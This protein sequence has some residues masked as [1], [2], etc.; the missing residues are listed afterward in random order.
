MERIAEELLKTV[1]LATLKLEPLAQETVAHRPEPDRWTIK[2][3]IGHLIDSATNNHQRFVRAQFAD[4][5]VF[6]KYDQNEWVGSQDYDGCEWKD[7]VQLWSSYNQHIAHVIRNVRPEALSVVCRV[8]DYEPMTLELLI[9]DYVDHL[10][11]H[12]RKIAERVGEQWDFAA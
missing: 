11:H 5:F 10:N 7:L 4:E 9:K 12:L 2:Q 1:R 3:V 8:G 6:P